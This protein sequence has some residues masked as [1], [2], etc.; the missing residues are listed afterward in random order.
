MKSIVIFITVVGFA[1]A[2]CNDSGEKVH[3]KTVK[4]QTGKNQEKKVI[5]NTQLNLEISGMSCEKGCGGTIRKALKQTGGVDRVSYDFVEGRETQI[6]KISLDSNK[7]DLEKVK[8]V[9]SALNENQFTT[10]K[11]E[12]NSIR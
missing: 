9:I 7:V 11:S 5:A 8:K 4:G 3:I 12:W 2:S 6:A 1:L 10:G